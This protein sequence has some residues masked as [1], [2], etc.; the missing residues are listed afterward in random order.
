M[1]R[2]DDR[3]GWRRVVA[4]PRPVDIMETSAIISLIIDG[5]LPIACGGGGGGSPS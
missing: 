5:F 4:S 2:Q 3:G 1:K